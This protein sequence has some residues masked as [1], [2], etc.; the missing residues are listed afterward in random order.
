MKAETLKPGMVLT[1]GIC[2]HIEFVVISLHRD[3]VMLERVTGRSKG[4]NRHL[5]D[6]GHFEHSAARHIR[7]IYGKELSFYLAQDPVCDLER[8]IYRV[9]K[10][11]DTLPGQP[12]LREDEIIRILEVG[13]E[14]R[15]GYR[16]EEY[17]LHIIY[18]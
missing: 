1:F 17:K 8:G 14:D 18:Q 10:D 16:G 5:S 15:K 13:W 9:R 3:G 7:T 4:F 6:Y 11:V 2:P 12:A